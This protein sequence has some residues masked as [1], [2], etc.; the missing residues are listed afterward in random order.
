MVCKIDTT[1]VQEEG[2]ITRIGLLL[3]E[4]EISAS[5]GLT[6]GKEGILH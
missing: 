4:L 6:E 1:E 3:A 2:K 5:F